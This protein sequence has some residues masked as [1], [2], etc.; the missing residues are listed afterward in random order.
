MLPDNPFAFLG[1]D[2]EIDETSA[3][4][5]RDAATSLANTARTFEEA[6]AAVLFNAAD[7][8]TQM[9]ADTQ[10]PSAGVDQPSA[11]HFG[12]PDEAAAAADATFRREIATARSWM[13]TR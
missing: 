11:D 7:R 3:D 9:V 13:E 2:I 1:T 6:V 5:M 4:L 12:Q 8:W 10:R